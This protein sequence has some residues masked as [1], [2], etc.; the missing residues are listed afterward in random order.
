MKASKKIY[1]VFIENKDISFKF[2]LKLTMEELE[3]WVTL[4]QDVILHQSSKV[5]ITDSIQ[6]LVASNC[7]PNGHDSETWVI[8]H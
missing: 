5:S 7:L 2:Y 8:F 1:T 4:N 3:N 6:F